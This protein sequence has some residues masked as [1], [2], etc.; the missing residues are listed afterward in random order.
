MHI[1]VIIYMQFTIVYN[2]LNAK[3][4]PQAFFIFYLLYISPKYLNSFIDIDFANTIKSCI[5][6]TNAFLICLV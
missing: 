4:Y 6:I 5:I 2:I 3:G 1:T